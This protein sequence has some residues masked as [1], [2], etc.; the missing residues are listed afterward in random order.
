MVSTFHPKDYLVVDQLTY[1]FEKPER[2]DVVIFKY[3]LDPS[4][5]FVKRLI[6]LPGET[7]RITDNVV[8]VQGR[9]KNAVPVR[10]DEPYI[11]SVGTDKQPIEITLEENEYYVLGDNR[12]ESSDSRVWGPL[13]EKFLIGRAFFRAVPIMNIGFF[14]GHHDF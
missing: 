8:T 6:G 11:S 9:G 3:P 5:Y 10:I 14:P 2:G 7:I 4:V 13:Q 12:R 1:R